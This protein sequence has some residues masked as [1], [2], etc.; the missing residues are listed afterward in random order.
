MGVR[1]VQIQLARLFIEST[2]GHNYGLPGP[3]RRKHLA[4]LFSWLATR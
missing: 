2:P 4:T 3:E 1:E